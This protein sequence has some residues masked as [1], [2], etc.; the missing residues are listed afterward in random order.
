[1][2]PRFFP[3]TSPT[4]NRRPTSLAYL[5]LARCILFFQGKTK[6]KQSKG[7]VC[8]KGIPVTPKPRENR[9]C[10]VRRRLHAWS[11]ENMNKAV[12]S[13]VNGEL[14][15]RKA[16]T[17]FNVPRSS[18]QDR[19]H[20]RQEIKP[21]L[22]RKTLLAAEDE[23]KLVDFACNRSTL[24]IGFGKKQFMQY[25]ADLAKKRKVKFANNKPSEKWWRLLKKRHTDLVR[26]KPEGTASIRHRL[27]NPAYVG[28]Y[29]TALKNVLDENK[30]SSQHIW[31]MDETGMSLEHKSKTILARRG[32]RYLHARTS[33]N[34]E[35]ITVIAAVNASGCALP[36]HMIVKGKSRKVLHGFDTEK[37]PEGTMMSVSDSGWTKQGISALWFNDVF[38]P[39]IG[40]E[41]PQLLIMD[42]HDSH[43]YVEFIQK[44][45]EENIVLVELPAHTSNWLQPL[46][47]SVFFSL[48]SHYN[49]ACRQ[50]LNNYPGLNITHANFCSLFTQAWVK[51]LTPDN[52]KSGFESCGIVPFDPEKVPKEAYLPNAIYYDVPVAATASSE[53]GS[54][55]PDE[56]LQQ[57]SSKTTHSGRPNIVQ[58]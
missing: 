37:A 10:Q 30:F 15:I 48:K 40:E 53:T 8:T 11:G 2:R 46:D 31:N 14:S 23:N 26:R 12:A 51:A 38:L 57:S 36:P 32:S 41:R 5:T 16:S 55:K 17:V 39:N 9:S 34:R 1:M 27:M 42:G 43:N 28:K 49:E 50:F 24:G 18:L 25:A 56:K 22:G 3:S 21:K 33:G 7:P 6:N 52:I 13:V 58:Q 35:L 44:A 20:G 29:F 45:I 47:R 54:Q 19:F 4:L